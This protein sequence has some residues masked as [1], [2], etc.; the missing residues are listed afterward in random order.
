M[1]PIFNDQEIKGFFEQYRWLSNF[2]PCPVRFNGETYPSSENAYQAQKFPYDERFP[3][4]TC[5]PSESKFL[6][7]H[8]NIIP[9][10][11][12]AYKYG[13]MEQIVLAK[14]TQNKDLRQMLLDTED[15]YLEETNYWGDVYWGVCKNKGKNKLGEILMNVRT[16]LNDKK[17]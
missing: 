9:S 10:V 13:I 5:S 14:F 6:G 15:R 11:W 3:F 2:W 16:K 17:T 7:K 1:K 4:T 12:E 8:A